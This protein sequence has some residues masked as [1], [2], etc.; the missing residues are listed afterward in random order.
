MKI[1]KVDIFAF[2]CH[3]PIPFKPV[4][5]RIYT[6]EGVYGDGEA[7]LSYGTGASAAF[8][9]V[10]DLSALIIGM[11]PL[12]NEVVWDK[13]HRTTFWG[14]AA[15]P[16]VAAGISAIDMALWDIKGKF[17]NAPV[18][19]LLGGKRNEKLRC[20]ASQIQQGFGPVHEKK[21]TPEEYADIAEYCVKELGYDAVKVDFFLYDEFGSM[22]DRNRKRAKLD[23]KTLRVGVSRLEAIRRRVG[24]D[25]DIIIENHS[26][27]DAL[28]AIQF[29]NASEPYDI[30]FFEEPNTPSAKTSKYICDNIN[31]PL[32]NGERIYTRWQYLP[33]FENS[34]LQVAQPDLGT[35]GGFTEG[36]KIADMAH[37]Y[38]VAIQAHACGTPISSI[39]AV[40]LETALPNFIIHEHH[41]CFLHGYNIDLC[42]NDYQPK[43]GFFTAPELPGLG[44]EWS[45]KA[46]AEADVVSV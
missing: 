24:D 21:I 30:F 38:D 35:C 41:L 17:F 44:N 27:L 22:M 20:Y 26:N 3:V 39:A 8:G 1:T 40:H 29:A 37:T 6:D 5:C 13:L 15:G 11:D 10:K 28:G 23:P 18:Y 43:D 7:A 45:E 34:C 33:Y 16:V 2:N 31:I 42:V 14:Q 32:A 36:K 9:M 46:M 19:K 25:V 4:G 12:D